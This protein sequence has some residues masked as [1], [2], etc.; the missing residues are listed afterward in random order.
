MLERA[1]YPSKTRFS[2]FRTINLG[3]FTLLGMQQP[4]AMS[5]MGERDYEQAVRAR[6]IPVEQPYSWDLGTRERIDASIG[7]GYRDLIS[8]SSNL[9]VVVHDFRVR[10]DAVNRVSGEDL[11]KLEWQTSGHCVSRFSNGT[12]LELRGPTLAYLSQPTE[13][14]EEERYLEGSHETSVTVSVT[15]ELLLETLKLDPADAPTAVRGFLEGVRPSF[16]CQSLALPARVRSTLQAILKP[17]PLG[18]LYKLYLEARVYDLLWLTLSHLRSIETP[19]AAPIKLR[20]R[21]R[22]CIHEIRLLMDK[23]PGSGLSNVELCRRFGINRNKLIHG[24]QLLYGTTPANYLFTARLDLARRL[25]RE[26]DRPIAVIAAELG[27]QQQSTFS[28][29]FKRHFG[30]SPKDSRR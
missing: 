3:T 2:D 15:R 1:Y 6:V 24:F 28:S 18:S 9:Y 13:V 7:S 16:A 10:Q 30:M 25:L 22:D 11:F 21:E 17:P 27:Y 20:P 12:E 23:N 14:D 5:A 29:A 4:G 26:T 19:P 8:L